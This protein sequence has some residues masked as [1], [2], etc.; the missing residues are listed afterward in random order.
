MGI[1]DLIVSADSQVAVQYING[2]Y[3][4]SWRCK[5]VVEKI[6][7]LKEA[8]RSCIVKHVFREVNHVADYLASLPNTE[9]DVCYFCMPFSKELEERIALDANG[10]MFTRL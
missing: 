8:F 2:I 4:P 5:H 9:D 3:T 7:R 10:T 1:E 6:R